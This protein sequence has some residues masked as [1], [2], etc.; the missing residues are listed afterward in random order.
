MPKNDIPKQPIKFQN[1]P[2]VQ[3]LYK[4]IGKTGL[5][6]LALVATAGALAATKQA[7]IYR[8]KNTFDRAE[9]Q[10]TQLIDKAATLAPST[11]K[12]KT[13]TVLAVQKNLAVV[14]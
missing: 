12:S 11:K 1:P 10:I 2:F 13:G 8:E 4:R 7:S 14:L 3:N 5:I 9:E 6:I